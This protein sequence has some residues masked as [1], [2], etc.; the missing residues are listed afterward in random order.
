MDQIAQAFADAVALHEAGRL[1]EA[2]QAYRA[3]L[4]AEPGHVGSLHHLGVLRGQQGRFEEA[5]GLLRHALAHAPT[6]AEA[7]NHAGWVLHAMLRHEEAIASFDRALARDPGYVEA[8]YNRGTTLQALRR[9]DGA[10]ASYEAA[11]EIEPDIPAIRY[12]LGTALQ[13]LGRHRAAIA[14]YEQALATDPDY[15]R[16]R[17]AL[18]MALQTL[19]RH[20]AAIAHYE[21]ALAAEPGMAD[22]HDRLGSA[23]QLLGRHDAAIACH[24][25][26]LAL[27]PDNTDAHSNLGLAL[28]AANRLVEAIGHY[29]Q[30]LAIRPGIAS[31]HN[32]LGLALQALNR[33]DEAIAQY[34]RAI[35]VGPGHAQRHG[36]LGVAL[37][38]MGRLDEACH[39]FEKAIALAPRRGR[40]YRHLADSKRFTAGDPALTAMQRLAAGRASLPE[41]DRRQL[42]FALAKAAAD[43]GETE[44][45]FGYLIEGNALKRQ[46]IDYDEARVL[47]EFTRIR[48]V[49]SRELMAARGGVG[50]PSAVPVFI[51][52]MPRSGTTLIEQ[53]LA[54]HPQVFGA[55]ELRDIGDAAARL[56]GLDGIPGSFPEIVASLPD[57]ML[58]AFGARYAD[59]AR[60]RAPTA[61]RVTDKMP[62]NFLHVGLIHLALPNACI[63]HARR[64]PLDTCL[65][66]FATL[67]TG[68]HRVAYELGELGRYYRAYEGLMEH[69]AQVLPGGV[70][71]EVRYEDV[72]ADLERQA[73]RIV[74]H[75][76]LA[77]DAA[78]LGFHGSPRPVR[79][80]SAAQVRQPIYDSS[81]GRWRAYGS[82]LNPLMEALGVRP[83][84][85]ATP[86]M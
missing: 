22:V 76:G 83:P 53:V 59:A 5:I 2:E 50:H 20:D 40:F 18:G 3:I 81:V 46:Q 85:T 74:V 80:A 77:W 84:G 56:N 75:C 38:E 57:D 35:A 72:V 1:P 9:H 8:H 65:S 24:E 30:V 82:L 47:G 58:R 31:A 25:K 63:I 71:L 73:R 52:G 32:N 36:N 66:C 43:L 11:L 48:T 29:E 55:G 6:S 41:E 42:L 68:D 86:E 34:R 13:A 16:A 39:A 7:H 70:L 28:H 64:D 12:S 60:A 49:F 37:Q 26:A 14:Q 62:L 15:L 78:C 79:T 17:T 69:W 51:V 33:H 19:G 54:S 45:S 44:R 10:I 21:R 67:F 61:Q 4:D 27:D 23:L